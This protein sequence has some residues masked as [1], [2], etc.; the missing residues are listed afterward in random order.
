MFVNTGVKFPVI[1]SDGKHG[2]AQP[3]L[4]LSHGTRRVSCLFLNCKKTAWLF[5]SVVWD[6]SVFEHLRLRLE[7]VFSFVITNSLKNNVM[8]IGY[9]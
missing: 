3:Y 9:T 6:G 1:D 5:N 2:K 7:N 4:G 8:K